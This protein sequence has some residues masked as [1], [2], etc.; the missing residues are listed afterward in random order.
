MKSRANPLCDQVV[1][2]GVG[3][4]QVGRSTGRSEGS[5]AVEASTT[6]LADAGLSV[7]DIDGI[8][9]WPD[10]VGSVFEGPSLAYMYRAL[11]LSDVRYHQAM[12]AGPGQF[13]SVIGA[14]HAIVAGAASVVICIRA[15]LSQEQRYY[16][17]GEGDP[18]G[19]T[20]EMALR[21]P[22]GVPA[23]TPR[24]AF[25]AQRH[26]YEFGTTDEHRGAVVLTCRDHAQLN[27]RAVWC[28]QPLTM[29]EYLASDVVSSPLRLLDC[30]MPVDGAVAL[31]LTRADRVGDL[32]AKPVR[33]HSLGHAGG[34]TLDNE[35]WPDMTYMASRFAAEEMWAGTDL[36]PGDLDLAEVYDGF[37]SMAICWLED[38][39]FVKKGEAGPFL[40][41]G[42][43][44]LGQELPIC[45]DGG[46]LGAGRLHGLGKLAEAVQQLRGECG[47]RQVEGAEV[48]VACAGGGSFAAAILLTA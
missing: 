25:W 22:Y 46:H 9:M 35:T 40:A 41:E 29:D 14:V 13:A 3:Y 4:S 17:A 1:V 7:A 34:P 47:R 45:T 5:L 30:D 48:A 43:G 18:G 20:G 15:H 39:G 33:I 24:Y 8:A 36:G 21:A 12:G 42:R 26:A 16:V 44:R 38:I 28:G 23:G 19:A 32:R 37:S 6:A 31:V 2:A 27:P 11:G 10:R